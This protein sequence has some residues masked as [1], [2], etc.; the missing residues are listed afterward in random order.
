MKIVKGYMNAFFLWHLLGDNEMSK[1]FT[2]EL[3]P[4]EIINAD[5]GSIRIHLQ[6]NN[7]PSLLLDKF[8]NGDWRTTDLNRQVTYQNLP[9]EPKESDLLRLDRYSPHD[10]TG[11]LLYWNS[12]NGKYE[13]EIP[14]NSVNINEFSYISFRVAQRY[15][16]Q[17]NLQNDKNFS[18]TMTDENGVSSSVKVGDFGSISYPIK[19]QI[20]D[21]PDPTQPLPPLTKSALKTIRIPLQAFNDMPSFNLNSIRKI[22]F[23]FN[24]Q[25]E[26]EIEITD[27]E[28]TN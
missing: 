5:D 21:N 10:T 15:K 2:G 4:Q 14:D 28:F 6:F 26:G 9:T 13:S 17:F 24:I 23:E 19:R 12:I 1:F 7:V 25:N 18:I 20:D 27:V 3:I 11:M 8:S 16:S 22:S